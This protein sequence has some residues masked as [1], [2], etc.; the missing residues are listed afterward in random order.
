MNAIRAG[1]ACS[2]VSLLAACGGGG[3]DS[4]TAGTT[5]GTTPDTTSGTTSG[6]TPVVAAENKY[7]ATRVTAGDWYVY[8][9][10]SQDSFS[11][12]STNE[13]SVT[14]YFPSV[15]ADGSLQRVSLSSEGT[16]ST[17]YQDATGAISAVDNGAR[18]CEYT[19]GYRVSPL[20][21]AAAGSTYSTG[22]VGTCRS[23]GLVPNVA[24][25]NITITGKADGLEARTTPLGSFTTFK[26]SHTITTV[27]ASGDTSITNE[28][29]WD[30]V[31]TGAIVECQSA[32]STTAKGA[33]APK[34]SS[35]VTLVL[36]AQGR[37]GQAPTGPA[38]RRFAGAWSVQFSGDDSGTCTDVRISVDGAISGTCAF[39]GTVPI[40]LT[41]Q[42]ADNGALTVNVNNGAQLTGTANSPMAGSGTWTLGN[43]RGSWTASHK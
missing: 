9:N 28:T 14:R 38:V 20:P 7:P 23:H 18:N 24:V 34:Y 4:G 27:T 31:S 3:G 41:G 1:L 40:G 37:S 17:R 19:A 5:S 6:A 26:R 2:L 22:T 25:E 32:S 43:L 13:R 15:A 39:G 8:T 29:C 33:T 35:K 10:T 36:V 42:I 11:T 12:A 21:G 16:Q 30:D